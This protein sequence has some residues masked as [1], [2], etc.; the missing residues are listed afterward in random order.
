M[1][2]YLALS[3]ALMYQK[4]LGE[5]SKWF[6]Y[7]KMMP[8]ANFDVPLLWSADEVDELLVGTELHKVRC[9]FSG[10]SRRV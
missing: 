6:G 8:D 10:I 5:F 4:S 3:L 1:E 2:G 9:W 7:L